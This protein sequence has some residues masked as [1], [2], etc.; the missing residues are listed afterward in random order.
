MEMLDS[1]K[2][3]DKREELLLDLGGKFGK[4]NMGNILFSSSSALWCVIWI[5]SSYFALS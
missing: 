5:V 4:L 3:D 1:P 2:I